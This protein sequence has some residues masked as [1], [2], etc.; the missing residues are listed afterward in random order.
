MTWTQV[1]TPEQFQRFNTILLTLPEY[2]GSEVTGL[3]KIAARNQA[4]LWLYDHQGIEIAL[5][6]Y[7]D[8]SGPAPVGR[9]VNTVPTG[10][11]DPE[12]ACK[13][14]ITKLRQIFDRLNVDAIRIACLENYS[15]PNLQ[16]LRDSVPEVIWEVDEAQPYR[17][18]A[19][20]LQRPAA[21]KSE[22]ATFEGPQRKQRREQA[23]FDGR[24]Q[25]S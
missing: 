23:E 3:R 15:D 20:Q 18:E 14:I 19:F 2:A 22:D 5:S 24:S 7:V 16:A 21:R 17:E 8:R 9:S 4:E 25:Q 11:Y 10:D 6:M 13:I 1:E 12:T